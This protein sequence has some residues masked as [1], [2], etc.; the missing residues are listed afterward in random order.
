MLAIYQKLLRLYPRGHR[1]DFGDE[2]STVFE[3]LHEDLAAQGLITRMRFYVHEGTGLLIGALREHWRA[4]GRFTM[5]SEFRFPKATWILMTIILA[6]VV[7]AIEKGE[8][9]SAS[10]PGPGPVIPPIHSGPHT[11]VYGIAESFAAIYAVGLLA[12]GILFVLRRPGADRFGGQG[13]E[14]SR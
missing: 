8:A 4:V 7:S 13:I 11:L 5:Q 2:M 1:R 9:I 12:W 14:N 10:V 3:D 6:G